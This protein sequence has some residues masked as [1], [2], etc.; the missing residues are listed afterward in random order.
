METHIIDY[1]LGGGGAAGLALGLILIGQLITKREHQRVL[2]D[3]ARLQQAND[4]LTQAN[5][6]L[7][8]INAN[9]SSSG[10]LTNQVV[11]GLLSIAEEH[12]RAPIPDGQVIQITPERPKTIEA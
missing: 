2:D 3:N 10:Q 6:Q 1:L 11:T 8:E 9:L 7:R 5:L 4:V 12:R